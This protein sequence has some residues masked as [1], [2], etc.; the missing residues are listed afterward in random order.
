M[1]FH[2]AL[3]PWS[4]DDYSCQSERRK[5]ILIN[6]QT[7]QCVCVCCTMLPLLLNGYKQFLGLILN[8]N[9]LFARYSWMLAQHIRLCSRC[10]RRRRRRSSFTFRLNFAKLFAI[11]VKFQFNRAN[12]AK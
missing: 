12:I 1:H 3:V 8:R 11:K 6:Q 7:L 10:R 5:L 9:K 4:Q 2:D